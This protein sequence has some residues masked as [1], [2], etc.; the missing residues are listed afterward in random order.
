[1]RP[2]KKIIFIEPKAPGYHIYSK[3]GLPRLG[4]P[5]LGT[6]L[7]EQ[8]YDVKIFVEE[9]KGIDFEKIFE[10]DA[11][12]IST[13][14]STAPRA[15]EI[16]R[17]VKKLG[18]PVF[19]G[20]PHVTFMPEEA[21]RYCDYVLRG[22]A[23]DTILEFVKALETGSGLENVKGLSYKKGHHF[24]H[25]EIPPHCPDLDKYP[26]PDFSLIHG[27]VGSKK[28]HDITPI[29]TSRGC[30]FACNFCAV[31]EMFGRG[32]R[33]RSTDKVIEEIKARNPEWIF[34]YDDNF[35]ANRERTK[36]LLQKILDN[37][38]RLH[39][40]A[41]VRIDVAKDPEVLD[42]MRKAGCAQVYIGLE[43]INPKT[44]EFFK[45]SQTIEEMEN[46]IKTIHRYGIKIH[47]MFI[48]G[49]EHDDVHTIRQTVKFAKRMEIESVQF[50]ML[51]PLP[52]TQVFKTMEEEGRL[53]SRDW[54]YY[55][56]HHVVF[57][58][59]KMSFLDLQVETVK[60]TLHF[61]SWPQI[62]SRLNRFDLW[63][64]IIRAYGR[65]YTRKWK[66][67]NRDFLDHLKQLY[68]QAGEGISSAG[69]KIELKAR[70]TSDDLKE[71]FQ[72]YKL[73]RSTRDQE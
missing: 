37:K 3:W 21:L 25:N 68:R 10:A 39:W 41:Q 49:S 5:I 28:T 9:V 45:K 69:T 51:V 65:R 70:K 66:H 22:E 6:I 40:S 14:T 60:A 12:G 29:M 24:V 46:A 44:L 54:S 11:V 18:I 27:F 15:Y 4:T 13:I 47:G 30:P 58:P 59:R 53:L 55:D 38:M 26:V 57:K 16:A 72:R 1:M 17:Q 61:Y 20:G 19:M 64:M 36:E 32:Y 67:N 8:G 34:F 7:K 42:L 56:G 52:G 2:I 31:T 23:E 63:T 33:F 50:I 73:S 71:K 35:T 48:F 43:S 62:L